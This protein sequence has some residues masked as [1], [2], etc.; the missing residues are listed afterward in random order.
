MQSY[1][2]SVLSATLLQVIEAAPTPTI[3]MIANHMPPETGSA[4]V[5]LNGAAVQPVALLRAPRR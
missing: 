3:D 1:R 4:I 5:E 2:A